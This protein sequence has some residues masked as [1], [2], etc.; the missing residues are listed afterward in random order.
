MNFV[1]DQDRG[2]GRFDWSCGTVIN[3]R[4]GPSNVD[5]T[6]DI[7]LVVTERQPLQTPPFE[8]D[9]PSAWKGKE[10]ARG[11]RPAEDGQD[12]TRRRPVLLRQAGC[13]SAGPEEIQNGQGS[14]ALDDRL[15]TRDFAYENPTWR[16]ELDGASQPPTRHDFDAHEQLAADFDLPSSPYPIGLT[17]LHHYREKKWKRITLL[18]HGKW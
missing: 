2:H 5:H 4:A 12:D 17:T 13:I 16:S 1:R 3:N 10:R 9:P 15:K 6:L 18:C 11:E 7:P 14:A 8:E